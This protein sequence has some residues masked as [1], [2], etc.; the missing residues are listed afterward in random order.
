MTGM[1]KMSYCL[2]PKA[3][4]I[5][6]NALAIGQLAMERAN[7]TKKWDTIKHDL[8]CQKSWR[9]HPRWTRRELRGLAI[10]AQGGKI[11]KVSEDRYYVRSQSS[12]DVIYSVTRI[13]RAGG[14][15]WQCE[16][17]DFQNNAHDCKHIYAAL[18]YLLL[19]SILR[20]N[21]YRS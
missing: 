14:I 8:A 4:F 5:F 17:L 18:Y 6:A 16:C 20:A 15:A 11:V 2:S 21:G 13:D 19:P 7:L 1:H 12:V 3:I 10:L 9:N